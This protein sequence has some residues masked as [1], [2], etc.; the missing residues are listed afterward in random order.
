MNRTSRFLMTPAQRLA[1]AEPLRKASNDE[2][3]RHHENLAKAIAWRSRAGVDSPS[4]VPQ[5]EPP[6]A[7]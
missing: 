3:A 6:I 2:P 7:R 4:I 1:R 5:S